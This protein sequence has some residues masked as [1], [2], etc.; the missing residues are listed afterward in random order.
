M[1][2]LKVFCCT[3]AGRNDAMVAAPSRKVAA[4]LLELSLYELTTYGADA[5]D[6]EQA[7]ALAEPGAVFR[8]R[9]DFVGC[10]GWERLLPAPSAKPAH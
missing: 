2:K 8:K 1:P 4:A 9:D 7:I 5:S 10:G 6:D 3:L